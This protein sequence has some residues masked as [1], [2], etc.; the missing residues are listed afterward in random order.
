M[1]ESFIWICEWNR[2]LSGDLLSCSKVCF[3]IFCRHS[4]DSPA[5]QQTGPYE[6]AAAE[7]PAV[8]S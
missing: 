3:F 7:Q 2:R 8:E 6:E 5:E 1:C 4:P